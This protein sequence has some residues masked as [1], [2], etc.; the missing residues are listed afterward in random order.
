MAD[1]ITCVGYPEQRIMMENQA[2]VEP[3]P[4]R[5]S[6][7]GTGHQGHIHV[8]TC[9]PLHQVVTSPVLSLDI[10]VQFH[11]VPGIV[12]NFHVG[13]YVPA[14]GVPGAGESV[15]IEIP[16]DNC[17]AEDCDRWI[18]VDFPLAEVPSSGWTEFHM[19]PTVNLVDANGVKIRQH[20]YNVPR[21]FFDIQNG[22]PPRDPPLAANKIRI[23]G[24]TWLSPEGGVGAKYSEARIHTPSFPWDLSTC[25]PIPVS[26]VW[27]PQVWFDGDEG[28]AIIDPALHAHPPNLG[29]EVWRGVPV[30]TAT[31]PKRMTIDIDTTRLTNGPHRILLIS[32]SIRPSGMRNS[33][34]L[35]VP[36]TVSN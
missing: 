2:W 25:Q 26:G 9:F 11:N 15:F 14:A 30:A 20:W 4:G 32:T 29:W 27:S 1:R 33:G 22:A 31:K 6:H 21:W 17:P 35:V 8:S 28:R 10:R 36:F 3:Q 34:I 5:A 18:H 19:Y 12:Q 13:T 7:P 16:M 23:G 24:D